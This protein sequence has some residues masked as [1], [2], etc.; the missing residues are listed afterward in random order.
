MFLF[1][2]SPASPRCSDIPVDIP[3]KTRNNGTLFL[4]VVL[5]DTNGLVEW[6]RLQRDGPTV[7]QRI[8]L[9]DYMVPKAKAFNLLGDDVSVQ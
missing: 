6:K 8:A 1:R 9:T 2:R 7:I 5:A 4:H 3:A